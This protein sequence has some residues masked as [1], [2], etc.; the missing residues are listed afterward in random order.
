MR[1][2]APRRAWLGVALSAAAVVAVAIGAT[3]LGELG[4][5][6]ASADVVPYRALPPS[7]ER[8]P[9]SYPTRSAPEPPRAGTPRCRATDLRVDGRPDTAPAGAL[10]RIYI[11]N[12]ENTSDRDCFLSG[13][14]V[15]RVVDERGAAVPVTVTPTGRDSGPFTVAAGDTARTVATWGS[16]CAGGLPR[17]QFDI[18]SQP[19]DPPARTPPFA[20]PGCNQ[21]APEPQLKVG[22]WEI[23]P[24]RAQVNPPPPP[25][26]ASD[27]W[28]LEAALELPDEVSADGVRFVVSLT[29]PTS[30]DVTLKPCPDYYAIIGQGGTIE[31]THQQLNCEEAPSTIRAGDRLRFEMILPSPKLQSGDE[32]EVRWRLGTRPTSNAPFAQGTFTV[33]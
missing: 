27:D 29:N 17:F 24:T 19:G 3:T 9:E 23:A 26:N 21:N 30:S 11:T 6:G 7:E 4:G 12:F 10:P 25:A 5:F 15:V 22:A 1:T 28:G 20:G 16:H 31:V 8:Q 32:A 14:P 2:R 18:A 13:R 33:R